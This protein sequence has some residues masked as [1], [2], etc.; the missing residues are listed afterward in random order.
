MVIR[1]LFF[2]GTADAIGSRET[3]L[4]ISAGTSVRGVVDSLVSSYPQLSNRKLLSAVNEEYAD[5]DQV[6][7]DGDKVAIFT[8]VSGG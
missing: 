7:K 6:L 5:Q 8:A 2:G 1:I 4:E 3:E